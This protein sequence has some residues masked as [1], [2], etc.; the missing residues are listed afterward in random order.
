[1]EVDTQH[2]D[3]IIIGGG[4]A[5]KTLAPA[6]VADG[7]KTALVERSLNMIGGGCIN[8]ACIPTKTMVASANVAN[9]VRNSAA[10]G[11]QSN[12]P[13]VNLA[14]V[15]QRKRSVV[16]SAR[17]MNLHNLET[18]LDSNLI[19]GEARFVAPKT[20]AVTTTEGNNRL[21]TAER[22]FINTG[23]RPLIPSI[24]GLTE[25]KFLTSESIMELED[26]P[27]H[28][29]VLGSGYIG[30]EFA[31]MF[32]RFGC[33]VTVIGQSEQILSQQDLDIAIAVQKLLEQDG[34]E[35]LL[36]AKVLRVVR[37]ASPLENRTGNKTL[38]QIQ[39]ADH[40]ITL[41]GSHLLVAVGRAPNTDSLNLAAAG[42]A[43]DTRGYIQVNDRLETNIPGI[44]ALGDI[45]GGPQYTHIS[46]DDYRIIK[47][48]LIDGGNR[49]TGDRLV[50]SCLFID[51]ELAHVGLT[52]TEAQ[53]QG[54]AIRVAKVDASAVPRA[55]T[56]GQTDG[57]LKAIVDTGTGRILG[58]SLLCHEAGEV[59]STVQMVMQAQMPYTVLR[60]GILT[61]PTM[62]EGLNILFSKL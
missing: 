39:V 30:L 29:I 17:E 15:I 16:Q 47:A 38:L 42:V 51:P 27:E 49:S 26:L 46:L 54:Y 1:M 55:K 44:W 41:Q 43:T 13:T 52:E 28:L 33:R 32:R 20:I 59:I 11:V 34:I 40:E 31:Q 25:V 9:T 5:G 53:Q 21:L 6:L 19:I 56:L 62:T 50:P 14:E 24:P 48:N 7:R 60:D 61:H 12:T 10:Y 35:F 23:T 4:K 57:L 36:K 2:Y 8:I 37:E 18:A 3:D 58:C 22:L 45:N